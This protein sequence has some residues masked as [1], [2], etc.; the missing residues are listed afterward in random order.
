MKTMMQIL[1]EFSEY[2]EKNFEQYSSTGKTL[3][4]DYPI[5]PGDSIATAAGYLDQ[6]VH[7]HADAKTLKAAPYTIILGKTQTN[8]SKGDLQLLITMNENHALAHL[9]HKKDP[10]V[11]VQI[12][13]IKRKRLPQGL[14][15]QRIEFDYKI[16][17][18][19][20][21]FDLTV[22]EFLLELN[23][24]FFKKNDHFYQCLCTLD[25]L[26]ADFQPEENKEF[27]NALCSIC[28]GLNDPYFGTTQEIF[29]ADLRYKMILE[30]K[31]YRDGALGSAP[32]AD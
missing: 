30:W 7:A 20:M 24:Y 15:P 18:D 26:Q 6:F 19:L 1:E 25:E 27:A 32:A 17:A 23:R 8:E 28:I 12:G 2:L 5:H 11:D 21:N 31:K 22:P 3:N 16:L 29:D 14:M 4:D 10:V 9:Q 13:T